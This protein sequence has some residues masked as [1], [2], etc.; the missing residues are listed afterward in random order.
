MEKE[1]SATVKL[2]VALIAISMAIGIGFGI[3]TITSS[4]TQRDLEVI[5]HQQDVDRLKTQFDKF[6]NKLV[7]GTAVTDSIYKYSDSELAILVATLPW[8][9][10]KLKEVD[11][12]DP[13]STT[14]LGILGSY[15]NKG[16]NVPQVNIYDSRIDMV[17]RRDSSLRNVS[18]HTV[19]TSNGIST[20]LRAINYRGLL[21]SFNG[22]ESGD[23]GLDYIS[24]DKTRFNNFEY[25]AAHLYF[26]DLNRVVCESGMILTGASRSIYNNTFAN[27]GES[28]R[29]E[30]IAPGG[31]FRAYQIVNIHDEV[32]GLLFVQIPAE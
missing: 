13:L 7:T 2:G 32:I 30:Y 9:D 3:F 10:A 20:S 18:C 15:F 14:A 21:G 1:V 23:D 27:L 5:E 16:N 26:N 11:E 6:D 22:G 29:A 4:A 12:G 28:T 31:I 24:I 8:L 19:E 25:H 17:A